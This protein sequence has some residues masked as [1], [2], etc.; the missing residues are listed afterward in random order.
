MKS[1]LSSNLIRLVLL[2]VVGLSMISPFLW[3]L[4]ASFKPRQE[5]EQV[6]LLPQ[7]PT[8]D[9]YPVVLDKKPD[10]VSHQFLHMRFG[11]W[12]FNSFFVSLGVTWLQVVSSA[13]AAYAFSRIQWKWRDQ[14]FFLYLGTMMIPGVVSMIPNFRILLVLN[15]LN[16]Y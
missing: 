7:H 15:L 2:S 5:V 4:S 14:V 3:M 13:M 1:R 10:P 8:T 11:R 6:N 9:N 16:S 12:Y